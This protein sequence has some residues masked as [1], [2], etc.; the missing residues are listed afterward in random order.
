MTIMISLL[1]GI[2][3]SGQKK[4]KMAELKM[5]YQSLGLDAVTTYIQSGNVVFI[6]RDVAPRE[7]SR[8]IETAIEEKF[9]YSV[10]VFVYSINDWKAVIENNPFCKNT[11][12]DPRRLYITLLAE[13]PEKQLVKELNQTANDIDEFDLNG[14]AVYL[15]CPN[16]YGRTKLSNNFFEKKLKVP[17]TTRNWNS[18]N[19]LLELAQALEAS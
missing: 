6:S 1:R 12:K 16:G 13:M 3:V 18:V 10:S 19:K 2:N 4:I 8:K 9:Y 5:L 15:Y 11:N 7:L 17:A 14:K